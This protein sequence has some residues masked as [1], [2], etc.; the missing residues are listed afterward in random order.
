M[1]PNIAI[2]GAGITG[3]MT[4]LACARE[5]ASVD[6]YDAG[7]IPNPKNLSWA[8]GRL[9][10]HA[11]ENNAML[12]PLAAYSRNYWHALIGGVN[13]TFGCHTQSFRVVDNVTCQHL[14]QLYE[15]LDIGF[16]VQE[17][18]ASVLSQQLNISSPDKLLFIGDD[19]MLL[20]ARK[21]Y[22]YLCHEMEENPGISLKPFHRVDLSTI[23]DGKSLLIQGER[24]YYTTVIC[25]TGTP[26]AEHNSDPLSRP[27]SQYQVHLDVHLNDDQT[28]L[29]GPVLTMGDS[30]YSWCVPSPD[31][32]V[33][34]VSASRFSYPTPPDSSHQLAC[35]AYLLDQ[36]RISY[37][38]VRLYVSP[39]FEIPSAARQKQ[40]Y[41]REHNTAGCLII[42]ACDASVFK[43]APALSQ[44]L[45]RYAIHGVKE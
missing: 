37:D 3:V 31:R 26:I 6:L 42:E 14:T 34:K 28:P 35:K 36:L 13:S 7:A 1:R 12:Q 40:A 27:V 24:K 22:A 33:L 39:Y 38:K 45:C 11:H 43:I 44:Q 10:K 4:A 9:W 18:D 2:I 21:I 25:T 23:Q 29:F 15:S 32:R 41:W 20:D 8:Y 19:A 5:G 16:D 17:P 30:N